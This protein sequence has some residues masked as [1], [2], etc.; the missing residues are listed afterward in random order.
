VRALFV[1]YQATWAAAHK[2]PAFVELNVNGAPCGDAEHACAYEVAQP[3]SACVNRT[4]CDAYY[5]PA[6]N[7]S[8]WEQ[9][10]K[11]LGGV[12]PS[13][14]YST[15]GEDAILEFDH[16]AG[17]LQDIL[18]MP[19]YPE[20]L[21]KASTNRRHR[22]TTLASWIVPTDA[23]RAEAD[24]QW[25][26]NVLRGATT[27]P[28]VLGVHMR[29]TDKYIGAG[30]IGPEQYFPL[31]DAYLAANEGAGKGSVKI[32]LATDDSGYEAA[33][34]AKYGDRVSQQV[35]VERASG[36][37]AVWM[38]HSAEGSHRR[39]LNVLLDTL[40][41]AKC[42]YLLKSNSA[43]SEFALYFNANL[44]TNSYD[45]SLPDRKQPFWAATA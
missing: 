26:D 3:V 12:A 1:I 15:V 16:V 42:D 33:L 8:S 40:M 41:L 34:L 17:W 23:V 27:A 7:A 6:L 31:I 36:N 14:I 19:V 9:Y 39:G 4:N 29:G 44:I 43:V 18:Q 25:N 45:F 10:F 22:A 13:T 2:I 37:D 32:Y 28:L 24:R 5:D 38:A 21:A 20:S 35:G 11:P 30:K